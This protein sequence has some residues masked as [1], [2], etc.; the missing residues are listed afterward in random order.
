MEL[1]TD[2][3][4]EFE[5]EDKDYRQ[6]YKE[7]VQTIRVY[8]L[9]INKE[10]ELFHIKK[11]KIKLSK[12]KLPKEELIQLLK[13]YRNYENKE[14][15]PLSILKYNLTLQP[16][17]IRDFIYDKYEKSYLTSENS[18]GDITWYD[19]ILFLQDINSLYIVFREKW[20]KNNNGTKKIFIKSKKLK[21]GKTRKKRLKDTQS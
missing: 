18:I 3:I 15:I 9:Y 21:R 17:N 2:W 10:Q 1:S 19:S 12:S 4:A 5:I 13:K 14:Y 16:Q 20:R 7:R 6:F 11:H 8:F